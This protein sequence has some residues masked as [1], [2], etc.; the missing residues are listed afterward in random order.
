MNYDF[1]STIPADVKLPWHFRPAKNGAPVDT[2]ILVVSNQSTKGTISLDNTLF[3]L[4]SDTVQNHS[5]MPVELGAKI[6][7][8]SVKFKWIAHKD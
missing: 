1:T 6:L 8:T 3:D 2:T 7:G 5:R 4:T